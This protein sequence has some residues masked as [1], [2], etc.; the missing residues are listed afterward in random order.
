MNFDYRT[1]FDKFFPQF[2]TGWKTYLAI[3]L[4]F[5]WDMFLAPVLGGGAEGLTDV[6]MYVLTAFGGAAFVSK[7]KR[8]ETALTEG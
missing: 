5:A 7:L 8:W 1:W 6:V 3:M 2:L 4:W